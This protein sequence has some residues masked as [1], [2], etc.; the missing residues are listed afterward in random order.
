MGRTA[1]PGPYHGRMPDAAPSPPVPTPDEVLTGLLKLMELKQL[2]PT[3]EGRTRFEGAQNSRYPLPRVFGGQVLGQALMAAG[4]TV[5]SDRPMHSMHG[6]FLRAGDVQ[7]PIEFTVED[8]K[9]GRAYSARRVLASQKGRPIAAVSASFHV[10]EAGLDH[11]DDMPDV[12]PPEDLPTTA[13]LLGHLD[14]PAAQ[15]WSHER[16]FDVRHVDRPIYLKADRSPTASGAVWVKSV[17]ALPDSPV[18]HKALLAYASDYTML[19]TVLRRHGLTWVSGLDMA[20]LD[21]AMWW[22]RPARVDEWLLYVL[23]APSA[24]DARGLGT[25]QVFSRDGALIATI[26]QE[27]MFRLPR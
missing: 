27:G 22:H 10:P 7:E 12:T 2:P 25:G 4:H 21:H 19:E 3:W 1:K 9:D 5:D 14:H 18:L 8:L 15:Y 24:Q 20:S 6:Y 23:H 17:A 16:A 11:Q 26:V 13:D